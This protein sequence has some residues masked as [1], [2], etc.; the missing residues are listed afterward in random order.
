[1]E[2]TSLP[3]IASNIESCKFVNGDWQQ[4]SLSLPQELPFTIYVNGIELVTIMCSPTKLNCLVA[5]YLYAEGIIK[6]IKDIVT[7]RVCEDD[8]LADVTIKDTEFKLPQRRVLT[9]GCGGGI[10]FSIDAP[11][12]KMDGAVSPEQVLQ[13]IKKLVE[14]ASAYNISGGIHTSAICDINGIVAIAE[15]LGDTIRWIN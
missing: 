7:M 12:L 6:D 15:I 1:M 10:S 8:A 13:L 2:E 11:K 4:A 14:N 5:G 3:G 9:S